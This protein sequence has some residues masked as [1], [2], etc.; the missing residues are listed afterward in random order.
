ML[1]PAPGHNIRRAGWGARLVDT[2]LLHAVHPV[3]HALHARVDRA[4]LLAHGL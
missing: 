1:C 4:A 3:G 2:G